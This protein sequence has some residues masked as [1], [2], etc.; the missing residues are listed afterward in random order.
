M[1][2]ALTTLHLELVTQQHYIEGFRGAEAGDM[3]PFFASL[4]KNHWLE[5]A[6]HAKIDALEL[7]KLAAAPSRRRSRRRSTTTSPSSRRSRGLL[8]EQAALDVTSLEKRR[9]AHLHEAQRAAIVELADARL[10]Q[11]VHHPR[12]QQ[13]DV[14]QVSG[15][16]L[17]AGQGARHGPGRSAVVMS[18]PESRRAPASGPISGTFVRGQLV[19]FVSERLTKAVGPKRAAEL[20]RD[21]LAAIGSV[22]LDTPG[23][24]GVLERAA[25][26][27]RPGSG[28]GSVAQGSGALAGGHR[29]LRSRTWFVYG[30]IGVPRRVTGRRDAGGP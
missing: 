7:K 4:L 27:P 15:A 22:Q 6:Q 23:S 10:P 19:A 26:A 3:D 5:E 1:A 14:P 16:V 17:A 30:T 2:V 12:H 25:E 11:D 9:R 21:T 24:P 20:L 29:P 18:A 13:S 28:G 8:A